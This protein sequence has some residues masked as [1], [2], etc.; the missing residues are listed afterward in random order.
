MQ[1][2][3]YVLGRFSPFRRNMDNNTAEGRLAVV[4]RTGNR[5]EFGCIEEVVLAE[6]VIHLDEP[7]S[8]EYIMEVLHRGEKSLHDW[9]EASLPPAW[10][11]EVVEVSDPP[12]V[13]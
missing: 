7:A 4:E 12:M 1:V 8:H 10:G 11:D 5:D 3:K 6:E 2:P 13:V 9:A